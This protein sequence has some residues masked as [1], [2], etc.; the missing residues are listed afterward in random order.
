[1]ITNPRA[2]LEVLDPQAFLQSGLSE[3]SQ[4]HI[5]ENILQLIDGCVPN[6]ALALM[7]L[8]VQPVEALRCDLGGF[9]NQE[10]P[11]GDLVR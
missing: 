2:I 5:L 6:N 8:M 1:M 9:E 10:V 3:S 11:Q 4:C 7:H